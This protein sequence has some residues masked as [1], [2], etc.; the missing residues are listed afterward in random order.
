[1][2]NIR[3]GVTRE[4]GD[5]VLACRAQHF[6]HLARLL[7]YDALD[8]RNRKIPHTVQAAMSKWYAPLVARQAIQQA[9][10]MHGHYGYSTELPFE[11]KLRDVLAVEIADGTANVQKMIIARSLLKG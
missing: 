1:M 2:K 9:L 6:L 7:C 5:L 3:E 8:M 11:Q 4:S 10:L